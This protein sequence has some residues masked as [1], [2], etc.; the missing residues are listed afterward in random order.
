MNAGLRT[1]QKAWCQRSALP[2]GLTLVTERMDRLRSASIGVW[3]KRGSRDESAAESGISHFIEHLVFKGTE[4]R[5]CRE[6]ARIIDRTGGLT[7]ASTS[8]EFATFSVKVMDEH[9]PLALDLLADILTHPAFD[10]TEMENER[11]VIFEEIKSVQD[12][13]ADYIGE[14]YFESYF[15]RHPL[16]RSILGTVETVEKLGRDRV[17]RFF[18]D[19]YVPGNI[20][21]SAAGNVDHDA[22]AA[23]FSKRFAPA[24]K[25]A[26]AP[27]NSRPPVP[28][29]ERLS[30]QKQ[31]LEQTH[32]NLG[33]PGLDRAHRDR[34][35][36]YVLN[37]ILGGGLS[38]RL[39]QNIREK[40]GLAYSIASYN[41]S[42]RDAGSLAVYTAVDQS[43]T[44]RTIRLILEELGK[45]ARGELDREELEDCKAHFRGSLMLGL[46]SSSAR[47]ANLALSEIYFQ[48]QFT[49][50]EVLE[51][52]A[53][54]TLDQVVEMAQRLFRTEEISLVILSRDKTGDVEN[55]ELRVP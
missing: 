23:F 54:V 31:D 27:H 19:S 42:F 1:R 50:E 41:S 28:R 10:P 43:E 40:Y 30:L 6:I 34:F 11:K 4:T 17:A 37:D 33:F 2:G 14:V 20:V 26:R 5:S 8:K 21:V 35:V 36:L 44:V 32:I 38:S 29:A 24:R 3:L 16:G 13:P 9:V 18:R 49:P 15:A 52:V 7:D 48:R 45:L 25:P 47:M 22:L 39:F 53:A 55:L 12:D 51:S 46:E